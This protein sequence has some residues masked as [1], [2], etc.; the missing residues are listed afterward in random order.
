M[1]AR[2]RNQRFRPIRLLQRETRKSSSVE[3]NLRGSAEGSYRFI[4]KS[5]GFGCHFQ[6]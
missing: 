2:C 4:Q 5:P 1:R 3:K 6:V